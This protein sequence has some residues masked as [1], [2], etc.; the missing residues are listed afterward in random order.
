MISRVADALSQA[1]EKDYEIRPL[2]PTSGSGVFLV[3]TDS[4][5]KQPQDLPLGEFMNLTA[6]IKTWR[7]CF[8]YFQIMS[9]DVTSPE[10]PEAFQ[11]FETSFTR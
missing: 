8:V 1:K 9:N 3:F 7:G 4:I 11:L 6:G 10:Y 2:H 5:H